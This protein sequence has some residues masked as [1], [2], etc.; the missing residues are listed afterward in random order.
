[1]RRDLASP[2]RS[3]ADQDAPYDATFDDDSAI[4]R[5]YREVMAG[6]EWSDRENDLVVES[7][8]R[9]LAEDLAGKTVDKAENNRT[10]QTSTGRFKGSIEFKLAN[11]SAAAKAFGQPTLRGYLPRFNYQMSLADAI[12][13][14]LDKQPRWLDINEAE[15]TAGFY[16]SM[17]T[18]FV[19]IA[20]TMR[21]APPPAEAEHLAMVAE[22]FDVADRDERNRLLGR[23]GEKRAL[24][25][26]RASLR[27]AGRPDLARDVVW[28]SEERGDGA[29][30]DI[31]SFDAKGSPRLVE[32]KTTVDWER[33]PFNVSRN[34]VAV[35]DA[36]RDTWVLLRLH[37]FAR[38]PRAFELRPP[39]SRHVSLTPASF[40]ASFH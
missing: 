32:V 4:G 25:Q 39:L 12:A 20:P 22:R 15:R 24:E 7:Y 14:W 17:G 3:E 8:F 38:S 21:N 1:M 28:V 5:R 13:R 40:R 23:A 27:A 18:L 11:V 16:D 6:D 19:G 26:E 2:L 10:L 30:Y 29:G 33:T 9:M 31:L 37:N 35:A 34:E 36:N